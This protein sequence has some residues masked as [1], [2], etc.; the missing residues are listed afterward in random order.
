MTR[1][2]GN[3][4]KG[5]LGNMTIWCCQQKKRWQTFQRADILYSTEHLLLKRSLDIGIMRRS[6]KPFLILILC[7][8]PFVRVVRPQ[9]I[10]LCRCTTGTSRYTS[11]ASFMHEPNVN[12]F[13]RASRNN[14]LRD[15]AGNSGRGGPDRFDPTFEFSTQFW[16]RVLKLGSGS[17]TRPELWGN[18]QAGG[19]IYEFSFE[20]KRIAKLS[21]LLT[22]LK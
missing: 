6:L 15:W 10:P 12:R 3:L 11:V 13:S 8:R 22:C 4:S 2:L 14:E 18:S 19:E 7:L 17:V 9:S 16:P 21:L 1:N 20:E 5:N